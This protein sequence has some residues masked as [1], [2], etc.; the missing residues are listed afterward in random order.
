MA[1]RAQQFRSQQELSHTKAKA[2][3]R[4]KTKK[5]KAHKPDPEVNAAV[6]GVS[7]A[8]KA[9]R[10]FEKRSDN[11]GGPALELSDGNPPSRKSTRSSSGRVKQATNLTRQTK[12]Q[13]HSPKERAARA[14]VRS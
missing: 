14:S 10:N 2:D 12:R 9:T 8:G 6:L 3:G 13:V 1:T 5:T 4:T 11:E 7:G